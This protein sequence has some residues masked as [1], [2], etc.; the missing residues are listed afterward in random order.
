MAVSRR[1]DLAPGPI[2]TDVLTPFAAGVVDVGLADAGELDIERDVARS[3][4]TTLNRDRLLGVAGR[5]GLGG[6]GG[7]RRCGRVGPPS[8]PA[9]SAPAVSVWRCS[10]A[11]FS[12]E[13][14][15]NGLSSGVSS[16]TGTCSGGV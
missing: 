2:R 7:G 5:G 16:V 12:L 9:P 11:I 6:C 3:D 8:S 13:Y 4:V 15:Q 14:C 1:G 10:Q